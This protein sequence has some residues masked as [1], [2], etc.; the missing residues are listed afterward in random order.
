MFGLFDKITEFFKEILIGVIQSNLEAMFVDIND[1][2]T[3][4]A[5]QVGQTPQNFNGAVFSFIKNI[6]DSVIIPLAGLIITA[7]L[8]IELIQVVMQRNNMHD[9]DSFELFKYVIKMWIAVFLVAHSFEFA[10]AAFDVGQHIVTKAA[11]VINTSATVDASQ[12]KAMVE[13]LKQKEI[14]ELIIVSLET[15]LVK[16]II[17][18]ISVLIMIITYSRMFEIYVYSSVSAIPFATMGNKEWGSIGTNYIRGLF[19]LGLQGL[20]LMICLGI[21]AVL[22]KT[23]NI[24]DIHK[25]IFTLLGYTVLLGLTMMKSGTVSK[26]IMNA[27]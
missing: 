10:M 12:L 4:V 11:G 14:G 19:A 9:S 24:T 15:S 27:H 2:V 26:S 25:S 20:F 23:V 21:Y 1:K 13:T 18:G 5:S 6:N 8:C 22:V 3:Q 16:W 17:Q 7:V